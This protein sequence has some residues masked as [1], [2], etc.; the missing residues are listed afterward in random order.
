MK[1]FKSH[2]FILLL[3]VCFAESYGQD[4]I[5]YHTKSGKKYHLLGCRYLSDNP[6]AEWISALCDSGF[7]PCS[8]CDPPPCSSV[9]VELFSFIG[10]TNGEQ[11]VLRWSTASE[12]NNYGFDIFRSKENQSWEKIGFIPGHGT[13]TELNNYSYEEKTKP[14][15]YYYKLKQIDTDNSFHFSNSIRVIVNLVSSNFAL[16]QNFPNPFNAATKIS[17]FLASSANT[18]ITLYNI[19]GQEIFVITNQLYNEGSHSITFD[20]NSLPAGLYIY[21]ME[22]GNF[23]QIR[24]MMVLK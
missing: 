24:K 7:T 15:E 18:K 23:Q 6:I 14:G 3:L 22:T 5:V 21:K 12:T 20:A 16:N 1:T 19:S 8:S 2:L 13:S 9:P 10:E 4:Q 11:V 17:F